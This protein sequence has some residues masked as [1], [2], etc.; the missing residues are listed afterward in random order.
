MNTIKI[1]LHEEGGAP[2]NI[3]FC[4]RKDYLTNMAGD[5]VQLLKTAEYLR[6]KG[7]FIVIN[8]GTIFDYSG[9]DVVHLFNL[10]RI[11]ETY[12]YFKIA[13]KYNKP[14]VLTPIYWDLSAFYQHM[15][16]LQSLR[17]WEYDKQFRQEIIRGSTLIFPSSHLEMEALES[18]NA[19]SFP[20][21]I[22]YSG[23]SP[24]HVAKSE[25]AD[26]LK[27]INEIKP[28]LFC[29]ARVCPRKNQLSL[30]EIAH[31]M[32][33]HVILAGN[34]NTKHYLEQCL[35]YSNVH[36]W[37]FA[38]EKELPIL[39]ENAALHVLCSFLETPGLSSLEAASFGTKIVSTSQGSAKEYFKDLAV[40]CDPYDKNHI[41]DSIQI[42]L[43]Q[44]N[45]PTLM[46]SIQTHF[47]WETCL[48][49]LYE[50]YCNL[51]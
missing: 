7:F 40:Y 31:K 15:N 2:L 12:E 35:M 42:G 16:D 10:T 8:N 19:A 51:L 23:V 28:Y 33:F 20:F 25:D 30:C 22:I 4:I 6:G 9:Y 34:A 29:A 49:K 27:K 26:T 21:A 43:L 1:L 36:F 17:Q 37:G 5:T 41:K 50:S 38:N 48:L 14:I 18:E 44:K 11:T 46:E 47:T 39:Y 13:Q 24:N 3:L 45:Q 32:G